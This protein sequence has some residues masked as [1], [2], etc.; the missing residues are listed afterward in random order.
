MTYRR[1]SG[2]TML[3][4]LVALFLVS[5]LLTILFRVVSTTYRVS[6]EEIQRGALESRALLTSRRLESDLLSSAP[7]GI[8]LSPDGDR[9]MIHPI[10]TLSTSGQRLYATHLVYWSRGRTE[11][12][13]QTGDWLIRSEVNDHP[14][15]AASADREPVRLPLPDLLAL[16]V[17]AGQRQTLAF[18][19]VT[20]FQVS[21][22]PGVELP[23]VGAALTLSLEMD[24]ALASTRRL[25][26]YQRTVQLR[27][28]GG[29]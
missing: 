19:G 13:G 5:I 2:F 8:T 20:R 14:V 25:I 1:S 3:E 23:S 27:T 15:L 21:N 18:E 17:G 4:L 12:R 28:A 29:L 10:E 22:P 9:T 26:S 16:P 7:A 24:L 6:H 11:Y